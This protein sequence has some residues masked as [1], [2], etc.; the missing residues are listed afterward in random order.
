M[1]EVLIS[2][3]WYSKISSLCDNY[4]FTDSKKYEVLECSKIWT[5]ENIL[6]VKKWKYERQPVYKV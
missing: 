6:L 1:I 4:Y 3:Y 5:E 2:L